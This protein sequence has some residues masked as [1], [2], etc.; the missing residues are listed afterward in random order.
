MLSQYLTR[1]INKIE[2][3]IIVIDEKFNI[4]WANHFAHV[5]CNLNNEELRNRNINSVNTLSP[6]AIQ[7]KKFKKNHTLPEGIFHFT[8]L[9]FGLNRESLPIKADL[10]PVMFNKEWLGIIFLKAE[11]NLK[12]YQEAIINAQRMYALGTLM[13][14]F[15]HDFNNVFTGIIS[16]LDLAATSQS[17]PENIKSYIQSAESAAKRGASV[18]NKLQLLVGS[19]SSTPIPLDLGELIYESV[20]IMRHCLGRKIKILDFNKPDSMCLVEAD[21]NRVFQVIVNL[22]LNAKESMPD[23]GT[24]L[25]ELKEVVLEKDLADKIRKPG[26]YWMVTVADT[27]TGI[28]DD[29]KKNIFTPFNRLKPDGKGL[30]LGLFVSLKIVES[31]GGW[32]EVES[33]VGKGTKVHFYLPALVINY[34]EEKKQNLKESETSYFEK[35]G[36]CESILIVDDEDFIR[37]V[38]S[39]TL[40]QAGYKITEA[41]SCAQALD[42]IKTNPELY[43]LIL[44]DVNLSD[45]SGLKIISNI[46]NYSHAKIILLSGELLDEFT[47]EKSEIDGFLNKP[48]YPI[49]ALQVVYSALK[50]EGC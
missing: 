48:F 31:L 28:P 27:G 44:L 15:A 18:V 11:E 29:I 3:G 2:I 36:G 4:L 8:L 5:L 33:E 39:K 22:C 16:N 25:F 30:G 38:L 12:L 41:T 10:V 14:G 24:I 13:G 50:E 6:L 9:G 26:K 34:A 43:D 37:Q 19:T 47:F 20:F 45:G 40:S 49:D 7:I 23:G 42:L 21:Q 35:F 1:E 32:M 46:R 17:C